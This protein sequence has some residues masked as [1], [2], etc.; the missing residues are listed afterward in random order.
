MSQTADLSPLIT[1]PV[2]ED[3]M[4]TVQEI[5]AAVWG[6]AIIGQV[7]GAGGPIGPAS[8]GAFLQH[9]AVMSTNAAIGVGQLIANDAAQTTILDTL[10]KAGVPDADAVAAQIVTDLKARLNDTPATTKP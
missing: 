9:C 3:D 4:P 2:Q 5:A 1:T 10:T 7:N 8:A 6:Q